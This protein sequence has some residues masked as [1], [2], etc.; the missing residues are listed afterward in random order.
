[1]VLEAMRRNNASAI[2]FCGS[3]ISRFIGHI[4]P[5]NLGKFI[6]LGKEDR[7]TLAKFSTHMTAW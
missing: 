7:P 3:R 5:E 6:A 2:T 4:T 1:M